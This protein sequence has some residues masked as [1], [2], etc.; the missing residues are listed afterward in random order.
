MMPVERS[1][2][3]SGACGNSRRAASTSPPWGIA[4]AGAAAVLAPWAKRPPRIDDFMYPLTALV[5]LALDAA[6]GYPQ[7]LFTRV[8]HPVTWIGRLIAWCEQRWNKPQLSFARRRLNGI[9][10]L[11]AVLAATAL[12]CVTL[13][14]AAERYLPAP[15]S[16]ILLGVAASTLIAQRSLN[17]HVADVALALDTQGIDPGR[18]AAAKIVGRDTSALDEAAVSPAAIESLAENYSDGVVAPLF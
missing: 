2:H 18:R 16:L 4:S 15:L 11:I 7:W 10:A 12:A 17:D 1:I 5:A 3:G 9:L 14:L 6:S 8:G 13:I